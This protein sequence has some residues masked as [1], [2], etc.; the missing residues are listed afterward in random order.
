[1]QNGL[2]WIIIILLLVL[3]VCLRIYFKGRLPKYSSKPILTHAESSFLHILEMAV[4]NQYAIFPQIAV[5]KLIDVPYRSL[6][7]NKTSQKSVDFVLV[8]KKDFSTKLVIELDDLSHNLPDRIE[9]D[10]LV[11]K[12]L[13]NANIP[14][15]RYPNKRQYS[16]AEI[17][18]AIQQALQEN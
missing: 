16:Q 4:G 3:I 11:N 6:G 7:W 1:M 8:D 12:I 5:S 14:V 18:A 15:L 2:N 17:L 13:K 10:T 9:R